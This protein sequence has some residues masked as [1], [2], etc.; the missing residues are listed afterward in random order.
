MGDAIDER[1]DLGWDGPT[2]AYES[3]VALAPSVGREELIVYFSHVMAQVIDA[4]CEIG[5]EQG[6]ASVTFPE[7]S[8]WCR[9]W[10]TISAM[11][12]T[13]TEV[14]F[15]LSDLDGEALRNMVNLSLGIALDRMLSD[16]G[17]AFMTG[18]AST[19]LGI[20]AR[21][22]DDYAV[23]PEVGGDDGLPT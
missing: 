7:D 10:E 3:Y 20:V 4:L 8:P 6:R 11:G 21:V 13:E 5:R 14:S 22:G 18:V 23:G 12:M 9:D 2:P 1:L 16:Y 19:L 15:L 17:P